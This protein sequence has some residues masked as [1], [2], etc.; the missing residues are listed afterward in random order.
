MQSVIKV[1]VTLVQLASL[2]S[3]YAQSAWEQYQR[4]TLSDWAS[5]HDD[6]INRWRS[7]EARIA[8]KWGEDA[9]ISEKKEYV[10]YQANDSMRVIIDYEGGKISV[11]SLGKRVDRSDLNTVVN[12]LFEQGLLQKE[13]LPKQKDWESRETDLCGGD[14]ISR[15]RHSLSLKM[16]PDHLSVRVQKYLPIILKWSEKNEVDPALVLAVIER[17]SA[18]NPRARSWV[19]AFGLMQIVPESAGAE[20]LHEIPSEDFLYDPENNIR[21]GTEYIKRLEQEHFSDI[22]TGDKKRYLVTCSYN[23]GPNRI[24]REIARGYLDL[25]GAPD[26]L[27]SQLLMTVP[28]ETKGYL[29]GVSKSFDRYSNLLKFKKIENK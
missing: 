14:G 8:K 27:F 7:Y 16:S 3:A 10:E 20:V 26:K 5:Y 23:W 1:L 24:R 28:S 21:V 13:E 15:E 11:E 4:E 18:F 19:P 17:E 22:Q 9:R 6:T 29:R 2:P 25:E 12:G